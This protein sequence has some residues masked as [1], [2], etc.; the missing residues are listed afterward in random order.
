[1][2][3]L[4]M[5][6][7]PFTIENAKPPLTIERVKPELLEKLLLL[8]GVPSTQ[9][10]ASPQF[11]YCLYIPP[12]YHS[13]ESLPLIVLVH[14][15][16]RDNYK[17]RDRFISLAERHGCA[18]LC[19]LFPRLVTDPYDMN[20]YKVIAYLDLRYDTILL[21]MI[22]EVATRYPRI[23]PEKF[24][25]YGFSGGGQFVHR[26]AYLQPHRLLGLAVGAPGTATLPDN[27]AEFPLGIK[28]LDQVFKKTVDW[29]A[30]KLVPTMF[31]AGDKD[32]SDFSA[33]ARGRTPDSRSEGRYGA[34]KRLEAAWKALGVVSQFVSVEGVAHE[35][36]KITPTAEAFFGRILS[37]IDPK[38]ETG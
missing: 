30:L 38:N 7:I 15:S 5:S 33:I 3:D 23:L 29:D 6:S 11:S 24:L 37:G 35:E 8:G 31:I 16:S 1:M 22:D 4:I 26:F 27:E 25:L 21:S 28:D 32:T 20:N 2:H 36:S 19:P 14:G 12:R 17:L 10:A 9:S 18:L 34:T 13:L